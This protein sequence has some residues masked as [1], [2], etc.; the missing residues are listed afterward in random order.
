MSLHSEENMNML[1]TRFLTSFQGLCDGVK[2]KSAE[3]EAAKEAYDTTTRA[4]Q[5]NKRVQQIQRDVPMIIAR[6]KACR[7]AHYSSR[8]EEVR[9]QADI[10]SAEEDNIDLAGQIALE[11]SLLE[12]DDQSAHDIDNLLVT[13]TPLARSALKVD[14]DRRKAIAEDLRNMEAY[15]IEWNGL[16]VEMEEKHKILRQKEVEYNMRKDLWNQLWEE[17]GSRR[18]DVLSG[19]KE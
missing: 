4:F 10:Q 12:D 16:R 13:L 11:I 1:Y 6:N 17:M 7:V 9:L 14:T 2:T 18:A 3:V 5:D 19:L 8:E 15:R